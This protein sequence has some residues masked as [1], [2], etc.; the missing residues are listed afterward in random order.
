MHWVAAGISAVLGGYFDRISHLTLG[1]GQRVWLFCL[2]AWRTVGIGLVLNINIAC[3]ISVFIG[4]VAPSGIWIEIS[5]K[6]SNQA[7]GVGS[8]VFYLPDIYDYFG[9]MPSATSISRF[10]L[11]R[12]E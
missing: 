10:W 3:E 4:I 7:C 12:E 2:T 8:E 9:K 1:E 11:I 5:P 6:P